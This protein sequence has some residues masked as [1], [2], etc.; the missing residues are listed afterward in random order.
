MWSGRSVAAG[1]VTVFLTL[2]APPCSFSL[3]IPQER[4]IVIAPGDHC[5][6]KV[7]NVAAGSEQLLKVKLWWA[8]WTNPQETLDACRSSDDCATMTFQS[9]EHP[10][11]TPLFLIPRRA[12]E[13]ELQ[14]FEPVGGNWPH[15]TASGDHLLPELEEFETSSEYR[16]T[17]PPLE[18]DLLSDGAIV[19]F[20]ENG[21]YSM[22]MSSQAPGTSGEGAVQD[23]FGTGVTL[24]FLETIPAEPRRFSEHP[25]PS[26]E[27]QAV[28]SY[29]TSSGADGEDG[30]PESEP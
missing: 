8:T 27:D 11:A 30:S 2:M 6:F 20:V 24:A 29:L 12:A 18:G 4:L 5:A 14:P 16:E 26:A 22:R 23:S 17:S 21:W 3:E 13:V 9:T 28:V 25:S 1:V 10:R 15:K 19:F 7:E